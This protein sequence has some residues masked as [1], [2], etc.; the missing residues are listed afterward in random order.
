ME[1]KTLEGHAGTHVELDVCT[2]CRAFWFDKYESLRLSPGAT[3]TLFQMIGDTP[4]RRTALSDNLHCPRCQSRLL[5]TQDVQRNTRFR[6]WRCERGH[7]RFITFF[8]FLRE[9]DFVRPLSAEQIR[10]LRQQVQTVNCSNCGGPIDLARGASCPHCGSPLSILDMEQA[11]RIVTQLREAAAPKPIDPALP[12]ELARAR[13]EVEAAFAQASGHG[14]DTD[15]WWREAS[16]RGLVEAALG[17]VAG[18][19]KR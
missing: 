10:Q 11:G 15:P 2:N 16:S 4:T 14:F 1:T 8:D 17:V 3:L 13:E 18:W 12:M 19:M 6:Y 9:K 5:P 7:G